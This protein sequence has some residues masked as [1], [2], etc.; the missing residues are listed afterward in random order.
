MRCR[1]HDARY[2]TSPMFDALNETLYGECSEATRPRHARLAAQCAATTTAVSLTHSPK[3][4]AGNA[5]FR[6]DFAR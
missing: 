1:G 3:S 2:P 5:L 4:F 6:A